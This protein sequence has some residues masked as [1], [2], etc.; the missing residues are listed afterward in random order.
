MVLTD[1]QVVAIR[2]AVAAGDCDRTA[3]AAQFDI[4]LSHLSHVVR[5]S[6]RAEAGGPITRRSGPQTNTGYWGVSANSMRTRFVVTIRED[7]TQKSIGYVR[8]PIAG[9]RLYDARARE[10][11]FPPEKLNFPDT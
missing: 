4:S 11:G 1:E 3:L 2:T 9:A 7:G 5:G 10:L 6:V 8:D